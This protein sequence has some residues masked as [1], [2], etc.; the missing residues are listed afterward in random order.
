M[1]NRPTLDLYDMIHIEIH[2]SPCTMIDEFTIG[3]KFKNSFFNF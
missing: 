3:Y 1:S 2:I